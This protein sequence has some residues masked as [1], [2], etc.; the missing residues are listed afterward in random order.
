MSISHQG[1]SMRL[2][3]GPPAPGLYWRAEE[4]SCL[5]RV[6]TI[7]LHILGFFLCLAMAATVHAQE[8]Y[9][10][11]QAAYEGE[12]VTAID[13]VA[14]PHDDTESL[15]ALVLQKTG[16]PYSAK[17]VEAS[18]TALRETKRFESVTLNVNPR[19]DGLRLSFILEPAYYIGIVDFPEAA[20]RFSYI[21]LLQAA[22]LA[23]QEPYD[24]ARIP[25]AEA[26]LRR[27]FRTDGYFQAQ[28]QTETQL[29]DL[30]QLA[31]IT[32]H[33]TFGPRARIG[34]VKIEG[35]GEETARLLRSVQSLRAR[36]SGGLLKRGK[37]YSSSR[38]DDA[39]KLIKR[40]LRKQSY[41]ASKV[42]RNPPR[43][44][45][46]TNQVDISYNVELGPVVK[47][48]ISGA[49]LTVL[50]FLSGRQAEQLL[51]IYSE[52]SIDPDLI[53]DGQ[54]R[55]VDYFQKKG[56]FDV[57]VNTDLQRQP[58]Q[59]LLT[60]QIDKGKKKKVDRIIF[61]GNQHISSG[62]LA[63]N[64]PVHKARPILGHGAYSDKL[65]QTSVNNIEIL[66]RD[67]G[68]EQVAITAK[69]IAHDSKI[70]VV[71]HITEGEQTLIDQ[72]EVKGNQNIP[73]NQLTGAQGFQLRP[74]APFSPGKLATDRNR[75]SAIYLDRGYLNSEVKAVVRHHGEEKHKVDITYNII[76]NQLVRI[77]R[78]VYLGQKRTRMSLLERT[79]TLASEQ[80]LSQEKLLQSQAQLYNLQI[81]DWA[82]VGPRKPITDQSDE[83]ALVK[84][85]EAK[86]TDIAYGFG[87]EVSQRGGNVPAGSVPVPGLPPVNIGNHH[88][89]SSEGT[90]A[91]PRG[92]LDLTRRNMRGLAE[93]LNVSL[94]GSQL[95]QRAAASYSKPRFLLPKWSSLTSFSFERTSENPLYTAQLEDGTFQLERLLKKKTNTRVQLRYNF[96]HTT[97]S[98]LLVP[99][100]VLPQ[101]RNVKLSS[102][103]G[104]LIRDTRDHPLDA[105][106]GTFTTVNFGITPTAFG[107]SANFTRFFGQ[108]SFYK[109][110]HG[111]VW[112]NNFRLGLAAPFSGSF[113]PTSQLFFAGGQT[114]L[115][116][117]SID[118]AGPQRI[119]PFCNVLSGTTGCVPVT[120]PT[121][122]R[123]LFILNSELRFPLKIVKALGG[124]VF[125]DGGNVYAAINFKQF[126]DN[127]SNTLGLGLRYATP[128]GPVRID[129]GRN[130][131]PVPGLKA[132]QYFITVGQMF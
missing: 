87:F 7:P 126:V 14:N 45:P 123:Q 76:E 55:L 15:Q 39:T 37:T 64:I 27:L 94:L 117:F 130:L 114:T 66:Y 62:D 33:V 70:D 112:A 34:E 72:V 31:N 131:S 82:S 40:A 79:A 84:V 132:T 4:V 44:N 127:Y 1:K 101:D 23:D 53:N 104:S 109:P 61:Q 113:V 18:V 60:Y 110:A 19:P 99:E 91:S 16:Q 89:E 78:V 69:S 50:P 41:L 10:E 124:V 56:Y 25:E 98:D 92:S 90:F 111:M 46:D 116:G 32:F 49:K 5:E 97:L 88:V 77:N 95:D 83:E 22:N 85:H 129:V 118:Q 73:Q 51:P 65:V 119:V 54:Q 108:F 58:E 102:V 107:S 43:Y 81:F 122:G 38:V 106:R 13:L 12:T 121:G 21:R 26:N 47:I 59:I 30:N 11:L 93:T 115:R 63:A 71:F 125:Y 86:R 42:K 103:S 100:L 105:H 2:L 24:K 80:P 48:K 52:G 57:Q 74:G 75:I 29:D 35:A 8:S 67:A 96:N 3:S 20:K 6:R 28:V 36:L 9:Q 68:Y 120:V 17:D 128:I